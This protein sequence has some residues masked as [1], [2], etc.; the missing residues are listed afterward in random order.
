MR[1]NGI[2]DDSWNYLFGNKN[3]SIPLTS[4]VVQEI[5]DIP[6]VGTGD[7]VYLPANMESIEYGPYM[8]E[9]PTSFLNKYMYGPNK[10]EGVYGPYKS[11]VPPIFWKIPNKSFIPKS[12]YNKML[13]DAIVIKKMEPKVKYIRNANS[14]R[15][16]GPFK[17]VVVV[18]HIPQQFE[19]EIKQIINDPNYISGDYLDTAIKY[20]ITIP[21]INDVSFYEINE[22]ILPAEKMNVSIKKENSIITLSEVNDLYLSSFD[23]DLVESQYID[24]APNNSIIEEDVAIDLSKEGEFNIEGVGYGAVGI[25]DIYLATWNMD[26]IEDNANNID[27]SKSTIIV[28]ETKIKTTDKELIGESLDGKMVSFKVPSNNISILET[29]KPNTSVI[30]LAIGLFAIGYLLLNRRVYA[31]R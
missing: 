4:E 31:I 6:S 30:K 2:F 29:F 8:E 19:E 9:V 7:I 13:Q 14:G 15:I 3:M 16:V 23:V 22:F 20:G 1:L 10:S 28:R 25:S 26:K 24:N 12:D 11:E 5:P 21:S 18:T 17:D 27:T